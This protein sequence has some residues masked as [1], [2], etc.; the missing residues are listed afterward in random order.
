[1]YFQRMRMLRCLLKFKLSTLFYEEILLVSPSPFSCVATMWH[2]QPNSP[3][4]NSADSGGIFSSQ[5]CDCTALS[6]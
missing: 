5:F 1:M 3:K 4:G 6:L 2:L